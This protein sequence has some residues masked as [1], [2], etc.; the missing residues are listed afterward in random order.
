[1]SNSLSGSALQDHLM[2]DNRATA[3][4]EQVVKGLAL[5]VETV[6]ENVKEAIQHPANLFL[7]PLVCDRKAKGYANAFQELSDYAHDFLEI[8]QDKGLKS[9]GYPFSGIISQY[10]NQVNKVFGIYKK[11]FTKDLIMSMQFE[12]KS[13]LEDRKDRKKREDKR[14]REGESIFS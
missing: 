6:K 4:L 11:E 8:Y 13:V 5:S 1:M 12:L 2:I 10:R 9:L 7:L 14:K 3:L